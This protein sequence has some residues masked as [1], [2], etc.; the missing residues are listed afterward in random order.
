M[1][2]Y[3]ELTAEAI[4]E[5][6]EAVD[7]YQAHSNDAALGFIAAAESALETIL[8]APDR[9]P[10]TYAGCRYC[11][12]PRYPF[13]VIYIDDD[14]RLVVVAIAHTKRE[15]GYWLGRLREPNF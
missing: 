7:W 11:R 10:F 3:V 8:L 9:Y 15:P 5:F 14:E 6:N 1:A 2:R 4:K 13:Q 12:L